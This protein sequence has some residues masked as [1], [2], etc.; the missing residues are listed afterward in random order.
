MLK[1]IWV[2]AHYSDNH[3]VLFFGDVHVW[4]Y[5]ILNSWKIFI[6][7]LHIMLEYNLEKRLKKKLLDF[8]S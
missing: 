8:V 3:I 1:Y 4:V 6:I 7:F 5:P 2:K